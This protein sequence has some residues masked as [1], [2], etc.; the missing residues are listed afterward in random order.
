MRLLT[1][2]D[3][4]ALD[5]YLINRGIP[6]PILMENAG[7]QLALQTASRFYELAK[8]DSIDLLAGPGMNGGDLYVAA[9]HLQARGIP[10]HIYE[11]TES[12]S[13]TTIRTIRQTALDIPISP[14]STYE[15]HANLIIDG[16]LG[17]G[18]DSKRPL[19][20]ELQ[21]ILS[22]LA[23]ARTQGA[24]IIACDLP[25]GI[26]AT[27]GFVSNFTVPCDETVS[28]IA[29]KVGMFSSPAIQNIGELIV[30]NISISSET[31]E[32]FWKQY[33]SSEAYYNLSFQNFSDL[34]NPVHSNTHKYQQG[35]VL[36]L[37]GSSGMSGSALMASKASSLSGVGMLHILTTEK[38]Y[39]DLFPIL[40]HVLYHTGEESAQW[41]AHIEHISP[42]L[43]ALLIGP[44]L[45][46]TEMTTEVLAHV[47]ALDIPI[48]VDADAITMLT[49]TPSLQQSLRKREAPTLFTPHEG[50]AK[51]MADAY[52]H[53]KLWPT[54]TRLE[55]IRS[56]AQDYQS[57][58]LLK[59]EA[60]LCADPGGRHIYINSTGGPGLAKAGSGD[61][62][63][64]LL[65]GLLAQSYNPLE[66]MALACYWHGMAGDLATQDLHWRGHS[67]VDTISYLQEV[68]NLIGKEEEKE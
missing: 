41:I 28:F 5:K 51:R 13:D 22:K 20:L 1:T 4:Q 54:W 36:I 21:A 42:K 62:L 23:S 8:F 55:K 68:L 50:E 61:I 18:F 10:V 57:Y 7:L 44:G 19:S 11:Q 33:T 48:V 39:Q 32:A 15:P 9:R 26:D 38:V 30:S 12:V 6:L 58:I 24:Y 17:T 16:I 46:L 47:L 49:R 67:P 66:A 2:Q 37:A 56:L 45:G 29:P 3:Q 64:G 60:S 14:W 53:E 59:G 35:N 43:D 40:P 34:L 25:S 27:T 31:L 52:R 63:A 65:T